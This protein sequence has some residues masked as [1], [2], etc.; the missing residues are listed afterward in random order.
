[1]KRFL[2]VV[3]VLMIVPAFSVIAA[4]GEEA[5]SGDGKVTIH[6][7][8]QFSKDRLPNEPVYEYEVVERDLGIVF[9][10]EYIAQS[11]YQEKMNLKFASGDYPH[12]VFRAPNIDDL[13]RWAMEGHLILMEDL[14][15]RLPEY[16][17]HWDQAGWEEAYQFCKSPDGK[18]YFLPSARDYNY[19]MAWLYR[20]D[21]FEALG[22]DF[23]ATT[24]ELADVLG[25]L[26]DAY[27]DGAPIITQFGVSGFIWGWTTAFRTSSG[28]WEDV[29]TGQV[30]YAPSSQKYRDMLI[31]LHDLYGK[32]YIDAEWAT[33]KREQWQEVHY[34]QLTPSFE[35]QYATTTVDLNEYVQKVDPDAEWDWSRQ[36]VAAYP[37]KGST[38]ARWSGYKTKGPFLTVACTDEIVEK[39][40]EYFNWAF[41]EEGQYVMNFGKPGVTM[42]WVDGVPKYKPIVFERGMWNWAL[43]DLCFLHPESLRQL[44]V[45]NYPI[46]MELADESKKLNAAR[47]IPW[48][49]TE[50]D[51]SERADIDVVITD[52]KDQYSAKFIKGDL[53][54]SNDADWKQ[55]TDALAKG[56][57][58]RYVELY[59][60][61]Y[62]RIEW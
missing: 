21:R 12:Y 9:D 24:D 13:H 25:Q 56:G 32:G 57:L 61:A 18:L 40:V 43:N 59:R 35:F 58:E 5:S 16:T 28:V 4:G 7:V 34:K 39:M 46:M 3:F 33:M 52:T 37:D 1:M 60:A 55:Y 26:K 48:E 17:K 38:V 11:A 50:D 54:P 29:D 51:A 2:Y 31:Y 47:S 15:P 42:D 62:N 19:Y 41:S 44:D 10:V 8:Y 53:D 20:K 27:P 6:S 36:F 30:E 49:W 14:L 23:P 45:D 22:L